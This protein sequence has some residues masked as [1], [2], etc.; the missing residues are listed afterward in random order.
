MCEEER[1][2]QKIVLE[3]KIITPWDYEVI[4]GEVHLRMDQEKPEILEQARK[5]LLEEAERI[6]RIRLKGK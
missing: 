6:R 4:N 2:E 5:E 1:R 3:L